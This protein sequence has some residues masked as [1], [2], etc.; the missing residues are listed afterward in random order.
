MNV[1]TAPDTLRARTKA[2][3]RVQ[4]SATAPPTL[5]YAMEKPVEAVTAAPSA[6]DVS[7][8]ERSTVADEPG[9]S[10]SDFAAENATLVLTTTPAGA[11]FAI[12]RGVVAGK[13]L[14]ASAPLHT[15]TAPQSIPD[16]P[17]GR[18]TLFFHTDGWPDDRAEVSVSAGES[19]PVD[20]TFPHGSATITSAPDGAEVLLGTRSLGNTPVTVDLPLGKQ[21]LLARLASFPERSQVVTIDS[22]TPAT[23]NFQM[24]ARTHSSR[25]KATPTPSALDK[26]GQ[27]LKHVFGGSKSPTPAPRRKN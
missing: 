8:V 16:L 3:R 9:P 18:Y 4:S 2:I 19:V 25:L 23:V 15:G 17:P 10:P 22:E 20:Y 21:K 27:S 24:Q 26:L 6:K 7:V 1:A 11:D 13:S 12:Y 5:G 14:P